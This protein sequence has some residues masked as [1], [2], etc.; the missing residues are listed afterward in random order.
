MGEA[1]KFSAAKIVGSL[2]IVFGDIGTSPIY[3]FR[4][5]LNAAGQA[6]TRAPTRPW[7]PT[8]CR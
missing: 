8:S 6:G 7:S 3:T 1:P 4:E 2:G 5:C